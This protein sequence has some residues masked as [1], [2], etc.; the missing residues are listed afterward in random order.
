MVG[1]PIDVGIYNIIFGPFYKYVVSS[2]NVIPPIRDGV[3]LNF[4]IVYIYLHVRQYS[5]VQLI[6]VR[7]E[8]RYKAWLLGLIG[9]QKL[10]FYL[11]DISTPSSTHKICSRIVRSNFVTLLH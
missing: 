2:S 6:S 7:N 10:R 5:E 11:K 9:G 8:I 4:M 1:K 3:V